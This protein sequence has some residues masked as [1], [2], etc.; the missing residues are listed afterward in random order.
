MLIVGENSEKGKSELYL[1][2]ASMLLTAISLFM[3]ISKKTSNTYSNL[4]NMKPSSR[5]KGARIILVVSLILLGAFITL[6]VVGGQ[7]EKQ[8]LGTILGAI[9][10]LCLSASMYLSILKMN[11]KAQ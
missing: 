9:S 8:R 2:M 6:I 7:T 5:K 1:T 3:T 4:K 11:K 10:S